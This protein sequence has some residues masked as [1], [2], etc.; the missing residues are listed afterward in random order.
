[1]LVDTHCG[2][3]P[4]QRPQIQDLPILPNYSMNFVEA[5]H[6]INDPIFRSSANFSTRI[7]RNGD[8]TVVWP[9]KTAQISQNTVLPLKG[10]IDE[11]EDAFD[12][13]ANDL[14]VAGAGDSI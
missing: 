6:R 4:A 7:D 9:D 1:M 8:T 13:S 11:W 5:Q 3:A 10:M 14:F 12:S 2:T